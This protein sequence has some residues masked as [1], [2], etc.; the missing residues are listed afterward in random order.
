MRFFNL[1]RG[2]GALA[3]LLV[4][5]TMT[6]IASAQTSRLRLVST[7]WTPF[8]NQAGQPRFALDLVEAA[9]GRISVTAT[10]TIVAAAQLTPSMLTGPYDGSAAA[11]KDPERERVLLF[12]K[13][14]LENRLILVGRKGED[15]SATTL[16]D[17]KGRKIA[18]VGGFAYG[19][20]IDKAGP[21]FVRSNG[22][23]DSLHLLLTS[24]VDYT[25]MDDLVVEYIVDNYRN[26]ARTR[27]QVGSHA[28]LTRPL[29][30]AIR[31]DV[32]GAQAIIDRFNAQLI[33]MISDRTYHR[34]LHVEWIRADISGDGIPAYVPL[35]EQEGPAE[36]ERVYNLFTDD[37]LKGAT[38]ATAPPP[39]QRY[40]FGGTVYEGWNA[41]PDRYKSTDTQVAH[42]D[43]S[44]VKIFTFT[45]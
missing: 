30:L 38:K 10:E 19:D 43:I 12:S 28:L 40:Y 44:T 6:A 9:L 21:S 25:L 29:Y 3:A 2:R 31:R 13:P 35:H 45:W 42:P 7:S 39:P 14:Y 16:A 26:E 1:R 17:L 8:T 24:A 33:A 18:I 32:P 20:D 37:Q 27:L 34:L 4:V 5:A 36:P 15:V 11:W 41:V 23:E 22:E